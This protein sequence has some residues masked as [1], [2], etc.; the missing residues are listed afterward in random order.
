MAHNMLIGSEVTHQLNVHV[1]KTQLKLS[2]FFHLK[3]NL[4][5]QI[6]ELR[7]MCLLNMHGHTEPLSRMTRGVN[8]QP[9]GLIQ[10]E[11][12]H[13]KALSSV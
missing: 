5:M 7:R 10:P 13:T 8:V 11:L 12:C 2:F 9:A 6:P 3:S 1:I 4:L